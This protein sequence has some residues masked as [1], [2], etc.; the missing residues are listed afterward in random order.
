MVDYKKDPIAFLKQHYV[1]AD[2]MKLIKL[3]DWQMN[4][5]L[6]PLFYDLDESGRRKYNI[7]LIAMPKKNGKS[8][9]GAG[10]AIYFMFCDVPYGQI[11][12]AAASRDQASMII[13]TKMRQSIQLDP[14]LKRACYPMRREQI[15]VYSTHTTARCLA[16]QYETA[17]GLNPNFTCFDE[18]WT[19][20]DRKFYDELTTVPTR[21][22]PL[23]VIVTYAG[24]EEQ[25]LLW[26]LYC[27]G[28]AG[29]T[30]MDTGDPDVIVKRGR[31]DSRMLMF[32]SHKNLAPW[33]TDDYLKGQRSR[34]PPDVYAR[35]HENRWVAAGSRFITS[36]DIDGVHN[37][38]WVI[39]VG[40]IRDRYIQYIVATDLGL[41]D[42]R[43]ARVVGHYDPAD[44][45]VYVDNIR[46]WQGSP[47]EHVPIAEVEADLV[48]CA[49]QFGTRTLVID[50]WQMEYV[51]QRLK[52][53]YTVIPFNFSSDMV[54]LSQTIISVLYGKRLKCYMEPELDKE[55]RSTIIR[56]SPTGWRID[57]PKRKHND[58][59]VAAGMMA[60]EAVRA[61]FGG[62]ALPGDEDFKMKP[63]GFEGIRGREF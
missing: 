19:F 5:I 3:M 34:L 63:A 52:G 27:D 37:T 11:I 41:S 32:W 53:Y 59:V 35:L 6:K 22:D 60:M 49:K 1:L 8:A 55:L 57:H 28:I 46:V 42:D 26:D 56:Q 10:I 17:A 61:T 40:P 24:Y 2:Q 25:G 50:P 7:A 20:S 31:S 47:D 23:V 48:N 21:K 4:W 62:L 33:V 38:P 15:E 39:Q 54:H 45:N 44:Q 30:V 36:A 51:I 13:Y 43:A 9:F 12:I 29:D 18:L 16:H 14:E 58:I